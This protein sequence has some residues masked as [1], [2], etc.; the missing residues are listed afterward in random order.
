MPRYLRQS[1]AIFLRMEGLRTPMHSGLLLRFRLPEDAPRG[2]IV[3]L[4]DEFRA[5]PLAEPFNSR[6]AHPALMRILPAW[7]LDPAIDIDYHVRHS[8]LPAPGGERELG[9]LVS[10]LHSQR[11]D[12]QRPP[13]ELHLI[14][15]LADGRFAIYIKLHRAC[16]D[17]AAG[18]AGLGRWLSADPE[19]GEP[20]ASLW[21]GL[22][23]ERPG[24]DAALD[25]SALL[26]TART[27]WAAFAELR[28]ARRRG[29]HH[30]LPVPR[31]PFN[32]GIS[33][34]RRFATQV[35]ELERF[36]AL[37]DATGAGIT[38]LVLT[39]VGGAMRRYLMEYNALP[40]A[41]M[42]ASVPTL[43]SEYEYDSGRVVA[44]LPVGLATAKPDPLQRLERIR[45]A[46][47]EL[48]EELQGLSPAA[49]EQLAL[50][51]ATPMVSGHLV[52][53]SARLPPQFNVNVANLIGPEETLYLRGAELESVYPLSLLYD[54]YALS[55]SLVSY[56]GRCCLGFTGCR[57]ALPHLQRLAVYT[58]LA[59]EGLEGAVAG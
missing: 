29:H 28:A 57:E 2:Y 38:D 45:N 49:V 21:E 39:V 17:G 26:Q 32:V 19:D 54:G 52:G 23:G 11:L 58:G 30:R 59:L 13:W 41:D 22:A 44:E 24:D 40:Q 56:A 55:V 37:R 50:L 18:V 33:G 48:R 6:L 25:P 10:R 43:L 47:D 16:T 3:D 53:L 5:A 7:E 8:A 27:E 15:G 46:R 51:R 12:L 35:Y 9:M 1:E 42:V 36:E 20:G 4:L 34:Q 31:T 14:E